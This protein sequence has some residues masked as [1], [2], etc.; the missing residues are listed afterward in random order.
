[1]RDDRNFG[2]FSICQ[3]ALCYHAALMLSDRISSASSL[4]V[5][6]RQRF[7]ERRGVCQ[8]EGRD[9]RHIVKMRVR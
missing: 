4:S 6:A 1:M 7:F 8:Y 5:E 9:G 2:Y 3:S